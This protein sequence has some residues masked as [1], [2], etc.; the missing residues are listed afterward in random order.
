MKRKLSFVFLYVLIVF[1]SCLSTSSVTESEKIQEKLTKYLV[2][3][4]T[5]EAVNLNTSESAWLPQQIQD[6]LK[7]NL[8][9]YL[10]MKTVVDS[11]T[12]L[13]LK[14]MQAASEEVGRDVNSAIE[15]GKI[16]TANFALFTKIRKVGANYVIAVD[17]TDLTTG[18]QMASCISKEYSK[19]EYLYGSTGAVDELTLALADKLNIKISDLNRNLLTSGSADFSVDAQLAI[20][21]QN[22]EQYKK[23]YH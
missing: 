8:Q 14:K 5:Q 16:T 15:L 1:S 6:K 20:I 13:T 23:M 22:E 17:F 12:E 18:E 7:S 4:V 11:K 2:Q 3:V 21:K 10:K 19:A 9:G